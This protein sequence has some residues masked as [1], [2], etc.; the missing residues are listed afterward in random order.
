MHFD[1]HCHVIFYIMVWREGGK[2][3]LVT[4]VVILDRV[5]D[6]F[7]AATYE[8]GH[9]ICP[10]ITLASNTVLGAARFRIEQFPSHPPDAPHDRSL[11][12][13][14]SSCSVID[15]RQEFA[16]SKIC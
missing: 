7:N 1:D 10:D 6:V 11:G 5:S 3:L 9:A 16:Q 4:D 15:L 14:R 12:G 2:K 8:D 13:V